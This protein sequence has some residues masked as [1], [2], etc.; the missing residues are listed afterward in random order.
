[1][2][3]DSS[4]F[5]RMHRAILRPFSNQFQAH[6]F[7][8]VVPSTG[9]AGGPGERVGECQEVSGISYSTVLNKRQWR[10]AAAAALRAL[11]VSL[12]SSPRTPLPP[13]SSSASHSALRFVGSQHVCV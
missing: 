7:I 10:A 6:N 5:R 13:E 9:G 12:L 2:A 4:G 8:R 3:G 1:M 11:A